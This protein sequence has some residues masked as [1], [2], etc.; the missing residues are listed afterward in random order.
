MVER[1]IIAIEDLTMDRFSSRS[2]EWIGDIPDQELLSSIRGMG[3]IQDVIVRPTGNEKKPYSIIAGSRRYQALLKAQ[4]KEVPCK[5]LD[6][7]DL[8]TL[9]TSIGENVGRRDLTESEKME[10]INTWYHMIED[11]DNIKGS[12]IYD[13]KA[14]GQIAQV[15]Y[16]TDSNQG[17]NLVVQQLR[18]S[19]LPQSLKILLKKPEERTEAEILILEELGIEKGYS[20]DYG[21]LDRIGAVARKLGIDNK[22]TEEDAERQTLRMISELE[23]SKKTRDKGIELL[24]N[25]GKELDA[26][27]SYSLALT[28]VK[29][30]AGFNIQESISVSLKIPAKYLTWHKRI[31]AEGH[32]KSNV[33]VVRKVYLEYLDKE[34]ARRK[35]I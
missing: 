12:A 20:V 1:K 11:S 6:L 22:E 14:T 32:I 3:L 8:E 28:A 25:F 19:K 23:L 30:S 31:M 9:K 21:T 10:A 24:S 35:W 5:I 18:I 15:M 7:N 2:S 27:K 34:A 16:G 13:Q 17:R 4:E 33:E 26:E 29:K